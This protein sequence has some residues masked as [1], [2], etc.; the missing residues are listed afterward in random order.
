MNKLNDNSKNNKALNRAELKEVMG[1]KYESICNTGSWSNYD[2][3]FNCM[4][5]YGVGPESADRQCIAVGA[6]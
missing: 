2:I 1:G 3:C 5:A 4:V 6:H